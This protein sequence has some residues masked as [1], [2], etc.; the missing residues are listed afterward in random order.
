MLTI[1]PE[2]RAVIYHGTLI[3]PT[4]DCHAAQSQETDHGFRLVAD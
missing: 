2:K 3:T 1:E 4:K